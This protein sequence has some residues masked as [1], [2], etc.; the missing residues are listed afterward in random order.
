MQEYKRTFDK[1]K[2]K[3]GVKSI[4]RK[5]TIFSLIQKIRYEK[6]KWE[7]TSCTNRRSLKQNKK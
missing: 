3:R 2:P 7:N 5:G 1:Y 6:K 4:S